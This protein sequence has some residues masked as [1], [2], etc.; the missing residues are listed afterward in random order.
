M[1]EV[2][3]AYD[4][5]LGRNVALKVLP[6]GLAPDRDRLQRFQREARAVAALDH[7]NILAVHDV[8]HHG[9]QAYIVAELLEGETLR[10][11]LE[12][13]IPLRK[14]LD[15]ALQI[16]HG[17]AAAHDKG[18]VHRD[19][20][21]ENVFIT[22][23][24]RVKILDFGLA[25]AVDTARSDA[26]TMAATSLT[27]TGTVLGTVGYMAPEQVRGRPIDHRADLFAFGCVLHEM[28]GGE[29][30]FREKTPA[31]T[32]SAILSREPADLQATT[33]GVPPALL[34]IVR[35]CL[36]KSPELRFQSAHDLAFAIENASSH[37]SSQTG[38]AAAVD[39]PRAWMARLLPLLVA[40]TIGAAMGAAAIAR[41]LFAIFVRA[42]AWQ[43][44]DQVIAAAG[45]EQSLSLCG[46]SMEVVRS[47]GIHPL[48]SSVF[49]SPGAGLEPETGSIGR[50]VDRRSRAVASGD[51]AIITGRPSPGPWT[52]PGA[53]RKRWRRLP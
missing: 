11:R 43:M 19:L 25:R 6:A 10:E 31:D 18:L 49:G 47:A 1:G 30:A 4:A 35:R 40:L 28:I 13:A 9:D 7:P 2:Y 52:L 15:Y 51:L 46:E 23:D 32:M 22:R 29:R 50:L 16:A 3:R 36:E 53:M 38:S 39:P 17:L 20:K 33:A 45:F 12:V 48:C 42:V 26:Q 14:T 21:P 27:E 37:S 41:L 5:R 44:T 8:G 24:D 34:R